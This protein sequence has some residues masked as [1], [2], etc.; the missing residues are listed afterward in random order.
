[1]HS[2]CSI[3]SLKTWL[4]EPPKREVLDWKSYLDFQVR[5]KPIPRCKHSYCLFSNYYQP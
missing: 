3:L 5:K 2:R 1:M 4:S